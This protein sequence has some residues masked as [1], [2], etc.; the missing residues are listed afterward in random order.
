M[1][2]ADFTA[3]YERHHLYLVRSCARRACTGCTGRACGGT[4]SSR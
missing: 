4:T 3:A 2:P 1:T